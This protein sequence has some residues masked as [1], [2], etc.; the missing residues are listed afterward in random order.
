MTAAP[1][2][3]MALLLAITAAALTFSSTIIIVKLL[4]DKGELDS[5][6]GRIAVGFLIVQDIA[7]VV[8]MMAMSALRDGGQAA[9]ADTLLALGGRIALAAAALY[10]LMRWLLPGLV[11]AMA[12]SQ[13]LLLI[14]AIAWGTGLAALGE[15][16]G[17]A[18]ESGPAFLRA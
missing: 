14:F 5:L 16:A 10:A 12:R 2:A 6:H 17:W 4:S 15:W 11:R 8:A 7:V 9:P 18:T 13:E 1:F 3:E